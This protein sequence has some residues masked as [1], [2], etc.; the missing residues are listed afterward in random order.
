[1]TIEQYAHYS[2]DIQWD[3]EDRIYIVTVPELPGCRTHGETLEEAIH[4]G[5]DAID[6]WI[7]A[8]LAWGRRIP[9]PRVLRRRN[10]NLVSKAS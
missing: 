3:E 4:Q 9:E 6:S 5:Q 10:R 1:M 8:G 7:D 2:M